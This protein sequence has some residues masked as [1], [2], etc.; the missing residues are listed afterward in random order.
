MKALGVDAVRVTV[1]WSVVAEGKKNNKRADDPAGYPA[2]NWD[3]YDTLVYSAKQAG[4]EV[5]F[6]VTGPGPAYGHETPPRNRRADKKTWKP[7]AAEFAKFVTAVG[8][9]Y[10]GLYKAQN[11]LTP[12]RVSLWSIYNEPN[13][14]GWLTPQFDVDPKLKKQIAMSPILYLQAQY[15]NEGDFILYQNPRIIGNS[16]FLLRDAE[17]VKSE[18]P[19]SR[20]YWFTYQSG[21]FDAAEQPKPAAFAYGLPLVVNVAAP[22][23]MG[24][25]SVNVWGQLRFRPNG[26]QSDTVQMQFRPQGATD[27]ESNG[28]PI[29]VTNGVGYFTAR[30]TVPVSGAFR[31]VWTGE[32]DP[33]PSLA[34]RE[35]KVQF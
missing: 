14:G 28:D 32:G 35:V 30:L 5:L 10:S 19:S 13:Q 8:R 33:P 34:S 12:G 2:G 23:G 25:G 31:A 29:P 3:R 17:P 9:R 27:W 11:G 24:G 26:L 18:D 15:L 16:Q 21:L 6:N 4:I 1:L 20:R 22:D 7:K